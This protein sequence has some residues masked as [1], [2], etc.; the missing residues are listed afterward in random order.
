MGHNL[1]SLFDDC[2]LSVR[3]C[4][5]PHLFWRCAL[6]DDGA[7]LGVPLHVLDTSEAELRALAFACNATV[8]V[9]TRV[10][11]SNKRRSLCLFVVMNVP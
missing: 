3:C 5:S 10:R 2:L 4:N 9:L 11:A 8:T 7:C 6:Q 1:S